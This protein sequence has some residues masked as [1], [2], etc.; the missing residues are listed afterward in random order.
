MVEWFNQNMVI[1]IIFAVEGVLITFMFLVIFAIT[2]FNKIKEEKKN[3][4]S[5]I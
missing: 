1:I 5:K 2:E 3:D 4:N